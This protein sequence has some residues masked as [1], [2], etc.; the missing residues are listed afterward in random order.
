MNEDQ[1]KNI[2]KKSRLE[3]SGGFLDELMHSIEKK[4]KLK[5]NSFWWSFKGIVSVCAVLTVLFTFFLFK[6]LSDDTGLLSSIAGI[7]KTPIFIMITLM[8]L[9]YINTILKLNKALIH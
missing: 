7:H 2:I 3:T 5:K 8:L 4:Q 1:F 9:Y 6:I